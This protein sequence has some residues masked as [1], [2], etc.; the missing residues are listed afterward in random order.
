MK[1]KY[2]NNL[3][4]KIILILTL[5]ALTGCGNNDYSKVLILRAEFGEHCKIAA[6]GNGGF[7]SHWIIEDEDGIWKVYMYGHTIEE[8]KS[9]FKDYESN[10]EK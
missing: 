7:C 4:V 10:N 9:L 5:L 8:T 3:M 6:N 2:T 1:N